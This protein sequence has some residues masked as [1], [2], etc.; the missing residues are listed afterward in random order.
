MAVRTFLSIS[1]IE[2]ALLP[3]KEQKSFAKNLKFS[4]CIVFVSNASKR[5]SSRV[6]RATDVWRCDVASLRLI[7]MRGSILVWL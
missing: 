6:G 7:F 1:P 4:I 2:V 5:L 3:G